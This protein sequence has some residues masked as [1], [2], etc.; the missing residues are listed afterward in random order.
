MSLYNGNNIN[1]DD[2]VGLPIDNDDVKMV[3]KLAMIEKYPT[4]DQYSIFEWAPGILTIYYMKENK[5][6]E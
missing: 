1:R 6:E 2:W 4:F 5:D 3:E